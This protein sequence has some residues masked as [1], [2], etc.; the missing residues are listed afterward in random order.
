MAVARWSARPLE[1][2]ATGGPEA[3]YR[4]VLALRNLAAT[5]TE[6]RA[7]IV[8]GGAVPHLVQLLQGDVAVQT[9]VEAAGTL[10]VLTAGSAAHQEA[11]IGSGV[12]PMLVELLRSGGP[13][14]EEQVA[15]LL[16]NLASSPEHRRLIVRA[17]AVPGLVRMLRS[18]V[19]TLSLTI[20]HVQHHTLVSQPG[21][22]KLFEAAVKAAMAAEVGHEVGPEDVDVDIAEVDTR[23][24]ARQTPAV[25]ARCTV[26]VKASVDAPALQA[27]LRGSKALRDAVAQELAEAGLESADAEPLE[28]SNVSAPGI[29]A[30]DVTAHGVDWSKL[31]VSPHHFT[32]FREM[33]AGAVAVEA[34]R[35]IAPQDVLVSIS[36]ATDCVH[37]S[38]MPSSKGDAASVQ[39]LLRSTKLGDTVAAH[40][41]AG[42][43]AAAAEV[44]PVGAPGEDPLWSAFEGPFKVTAVTKPELK[45]VTYTQSGTRGGQKQAAGA[46]RHLVYDERDHQDVVVAAGALEPLVDLLRPSV[47]FGD[48]FA[49]IDRSNGGNIS[50]PELAQG[51][52]A[53]GYE[54]P[55][56]ELWK[57]LD[58]D[59]SG[60][61]TWQEFVDRLREEEALQQ[62]GTLQAREVNGPTSEFLAFLLHRF[63]STPVQEQ[64]A[65]ALRAL[66]LNNED[67]PEQVLTAGAVLPLVDLVRT[68]PVEAREQAN[69]ALRLLAAPYAAS[70]VQEMS[71]K[72]VPQ[73]A[74]AAGGLRHLAAAG[75]EYRRKVVAAGAIPLLVSQLDSESPSL[76]EE[77][78]GALVNVM[79]K[80][81][82][83]EK[84]VV[85][86]GAVP[87][88][89]ANLLRK[90]PGVQIVSARAVC[91]LAAGKQEHR[92]E[93]I[94]AG[95][96]ATSRSD[97]LLNWSQQGVALLRFASRAVA[98]R[99]QSH[100]VEGMH[101]RG[102][103]P[104]ARGESDVC[105]VN[106]SLDRGSFGPARA[107]SS[108][109]Q[110]L[111]QRS[112]DS[113]L[114]APQ[115]LQAAFNPAD[116]QAWEPHRF[117][118]VGKLQ[119]AVRNRGQ[120]HH[121]LDTSS[122]RHVAVKKM[123]NAWVCKS[124]DD[125]IRQHLWETEKPWRDIGCTAFLNAVGFPYACRLLG[126]YRD[127]DFTSVVSE[128][129]TEG[130]FFSWCTAPTAPPP[131]P[132]REALI[133]PL[134]KQMLD[135]VLRLHEM[136]VVHRDLSLENILL[137]R[138]ATDG[139]LRIHIID[140]GVASA[141]RRFRNCV[142]GKPSY[143]AP[144]MYT[145][146]EYDGFLVDVFALGVVLYTAFVADYPWSSTRPGNCHCFDFVR[147]YGLHAYV[148]KRR[149]RH[150]K[151][152]VGQHM[153][154]AFIHLLEGLLAFDPSQ[155][156]SLGESVW[157]ARK[158]VWQESWLVDP[159]LPKQT[160]AG[161]KRTRSF[162]MRRCM[163]P[164]GKVALNRR[165]LVTG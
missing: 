160:S 56:Q 45:E 153:S 49:A 135:G 5:S 148:Q 123:P 22:L 91:M 122:G 109:Q 121:M 164:A 129:A 149:A 137:S 7:K 1:L 155:R 17:G 161:R 19:I 44:I 90:F 150:Q 117:K 50:V 30:F 75:G 133:L 62:E 9:R 48:V 89:L 116:V 68:G 107:I 103:L 57:E 60:A 144:E 156:L 73:R 126:V 111:T 99:Q 15:G 63:D 158:S 29:V 58:R 130:D 70:K 18:K 136:S 147:K 36:P 101:Q 119:D 13:S 165:I 71:S 81:P 4:A 141:T 40:V 42:L 88:L 55:V 37:C 131:G 76:Q 157:T 84:A 124:H 143:Q 92:S 14:V 145:N 110:S 78:M 11:V 102:G 128:L 69:A 52:L 74:Q 27:A 86:A 8:E 105:S 54:A 51:L 28:V 61:I 125:F 115:A 79:I 64:A 41:A 118:M 96:V 152:A 93:V 127:E 120:V 47:P 139:T 159:R 146:D 142:R 20:L 33:V 140:F 23:R 95:G 82:E 12:V 154:E 77:A 34:G 113:V 66:L 21:Q 26:M 25:L 112:S 134:A 6:H 114:R 87:H 108:T 100:C 39:K 59:R 32:A 43:A 83:H 38:I 98:T 104:C 151:E 85:A 16:M 65:G 94:E 163:H 10:R 72:S 46:L 3:K 35:A 24:V 53:M 138:S 162:G 106:A 2:L 80:N 31:L 132:A 97:R 67:T